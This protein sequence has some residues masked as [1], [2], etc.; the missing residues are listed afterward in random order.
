MHLLDGSTASV[1]LLSIDRIDKTFAEQNDS[2]YV[3]I[4]KN[5]FLYHD[6]DAF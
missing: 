3:V 2:G 1:G 6:F 4:I 5:L